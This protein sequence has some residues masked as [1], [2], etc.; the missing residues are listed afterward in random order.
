LGTSID[1]RHEPPRAGD[2]RHSQAD[3][4]QARADLAYEPLV[5]LEEGLRR[6]VDHYRKIA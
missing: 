4:S 5:N 2:V 1:P 6:A 3:I